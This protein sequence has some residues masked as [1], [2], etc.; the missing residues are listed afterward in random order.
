M[1][2][3]TL[4]A[5]IPL[6]CGQEAAQSTIPNTMTSDDNLDTAA[7]TEISPVDVFTD[8]HEDAEMNADYYVSASVGNDDY[9]DGTKAYPFRT[10]QEAIDV[11]Q[12]GQS[13]FLL[14]GVYR[15]AITTTRDGTND[16]KIS[17]IANPR[18]GAVIMGTDR[19]TNWSRYRGNI[20]SAPV[21][22]RVTQLFVL[23][24]NYNF[25]AGAS[26]NPGEPMIEARWP[27]QNGTSRGIFESLDRDP[28]N[29]AGA[30][31]SG[32]TIKIGGLPGGNYA[33]AKY[34][35][36][37]SSSGQRWWAIS[38]RVVSNRG[39]ALRV[40]GTNGFLTNNMRAYVAGPLHLLDRP[41]EWAYQ[42][43]RLYFWAPGNANPARLRVEAKVRPL[44]LDIRNSNVNINGLKIFG[45]A[46]DV[47]GRNVKIRNVDGRFMT[48][49]L[50][51]NHRRRHDRQPDPT[52]GVRL[53]GNNNS[54][55]NSRLYY[56][57]CEAVT[58]T[59]SRNVVD[60]N[61]L[62]VTSY[63]AHFLHSI[64]LQGNNNLVIGNTVA[65]TGK[66]NLRILPGARQNRILYNSLSANG[67]VAHDLG[68]I[69]LWG[70]S[71]KG[72]EIAYNWV[73]DN[74][75]T[76]VAR[77]N[78]GIYLDNN[79]KD[80]LIHHNAIWNI[81][82]NPIR[83][84]SPQYNIYVYNNTI[85]GGEEMVGQNVYFNPSLKDPDTGRRVAN[86]FG[87]V[88]FANNYVWRGFAFPRQ[89]RG[90]RYWNN[91]ATGD[92][93]A[94]AYPRFFIGAGSPAQNVGRH[95][96]PV[97]FSSG[98]SFPSVT[99]LVNGPPDAGAYEVGRTR[100]RPGINRVEAR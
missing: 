4:I 34:Y 69:V 39:N 1:R 22:K 57:A 58:V 2:L 64:T 93:N 25:R 81:R 70:V 74:I 62:V 6:A 94:L 40:S 71:T 55:A 53:A 12:P 21:G 41:G 66:E 84:N 45:A 78:H 29:F 80:I 5:L 8:D 10:I 61:H 30:S 65:H 68:N 20:Y 13:A 43:G 42:N 32:S 14:P 77:G 7:F 59:G 26:L 79:N 27:N 100:W 67:H 37:G 56:N 75:A 3:I 9:S 60:N 95:L 88:N 92:R 38:E 85:G 48:S 17:L 18:A 73:H 16:Q 33:G 11:M 35:S 50:F 89:Y 31:K 96:D 90:I 72:T 52:A 24:G 15:E 36:L 44:A 82:G 19:V 46:I 98:V 97:R 91:K 47:T 86:Q 76:S 54:L 63:Y 28:R 23:R 49:A 51:V 87:N 83:F 99:R